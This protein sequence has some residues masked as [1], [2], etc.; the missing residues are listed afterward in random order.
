[1]NRPLSF[2]PELCAALPP[3][4]GNVDYRDWR[5]TLE[6][7]DRI[8]REAGLEADFAGRYLEQ[9]EQE[10][11]TR[12]E[13]RGRAAG[14]LTPRQ[15]RRLERY[16]RQAFRC[17]LART[18][19]GEPYRD[20]AAHLAD[21]PLLQRFCLCAA[22]EQVRVPS[23]SSLE[24]FDKIAPAET[25]RAIVEGLSVKAVSKEEAVGQLGLAEPLNVEAC[26]VD[27][28]CVA[29][30]IHFPV[31]WVLLR[32]G[33]R[34]LMLAVSLIRRHGLRHRMEEPE[35]FLAE[36]NRLAIEMTNARRKRGARRAR[37][38]VLRRM[39]RLCKTV[40]GHAERH[41]DLLQAEWTDT[42]LSEGE[43][44]QI[45]GRIEGVLR[46]L[47]AAARQARERIIGGRQVDNE[48]KILSLYEPDAQV[49][50]RGKTNAEVE[51]G[52]T[53]LLG[54]QSEGLIVDWML[55]KDQAPA[56]PKLLPPSIERLK[57]VFGEHT[58]KAIAT[59]R[60]FHSAANETLLELQDVYDAT[61]PRQPGRMAERRREEMFVAL[62]KRRAQTEARVSILKNAF[63]GRPLRA[64]GFEHRETTVA[65]CVLTHNLWLIA[66]L[67][68]AA[69]QEALHRR[70]TA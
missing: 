15:R 66:R 54:E 23:K 24:R 63:L 61:C 9:W 22:I 19:T 40:R 67:A 37:K 59:D 20:F 13:R 60:G 25:I 8:L 38:L 33:V 3:V 31:D 21:S 29:A 14:P 12:R 44:R 35:T 10:W 46:Q 32:D 2:Q 16:A 49:I 27:T 52:N 36:M 11:V 43:V 39:C 5:D 4:S 17:N 26:F 45:V 50:V 18:L 6:R 30:N 56:D 7:L 53:L 1:M 34:T 42:D 70:K 57:R 48:E 58:V 62:Q 41:R 28:T 69:A 64:K 65:W 47:P 55:F 68:R 51:F